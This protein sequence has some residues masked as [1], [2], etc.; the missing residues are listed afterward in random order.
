MK[1]GILLMHLL[2][3]FSIFISCTNQ[4]RESKETSTS[5]KTEFI[6]LGYVA[7]GKD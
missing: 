6:I 5:E 3:I 4:S 1:Q 2:V 7:G